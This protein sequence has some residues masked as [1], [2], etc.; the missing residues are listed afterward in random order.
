[1]PEFDLCPGSDLDPMPEFDFYPGSDL[2]ST[3]PPDAAV[4]VDAPWPTRVSSNPVTQYSSTSP[5]QGIH[6]RQPSSPR[7]AQ[8]IGVRGVAQMQHAGPHRR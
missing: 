5:T 7:Q 6:D 2:D 8:V 3:D 4:D 1:M